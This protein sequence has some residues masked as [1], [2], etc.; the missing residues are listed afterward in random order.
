MPAESANRDIL[1]P[2]QLGEGDD[3]LAH[4]GAVAHVL[5]APAEP[6]SKGTEPSAQASI[7]HGAMIA[8]PAHPGLTR[9]SPGAH[10]TRRHVRLER[11]RH[12][13]LQLQ[14]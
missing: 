14:E 11:A 3:I 12:Q 7:I 8:G 13:R 5:L 6:M 4:S 9:G 1:D 10:L 2:A